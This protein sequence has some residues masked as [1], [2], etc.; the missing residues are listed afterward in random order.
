[1][2]SLSKRQY[3]EKVN[4]IK[5]QIEKGEYKW[6]NAHKNP[7]V[8]ILVK[9]GGR[10]NSLINLIHSIFTNVDSIPYKIYIADDGKRNRLKN[11]IYRRLEG[12]GHSVKLFEYNIGA[13]VSRN[14]I[15]QTIEEDFVLRLDDDFE[16]L[17]STNILTMK[18][19]LKGSSTF[20]AVSSL[21]IQI[22]H[23]KNVLDG[24]VSPHQG[25][26]GFEQDKLTKKRIDLNKT[27]FR[28]KNGNRYLICDYTRNFLLCKAEIFNDI[29][30]DERISFHG[31]HED[32]MLQIYHSE[33]DLLCT[34]D[35][36][37]GHNEK[38]PNSSLEYE[39]KRNSTK[40][41]K[42]ESSRPIQ[43]FEEKWGIK[44]IEVERTFIDYVRVIII[45]VLSYW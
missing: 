37:H 44:S 7:E 4:E 22:G 20:G 3:V 14:K 31:E 21:E 36:Y 26:F 16:L 18:S 29:K 25:F 6:H 8:A 11:K 30:W 12:G 34:P 15:V 39:R 42:K 38:I 33:W 19:I 45:K 28:H 9:T 27:A 41:G 24:Q 10:L 32:F 13:T 40:D 1:M 5:S 23:G 2:N 17:P 43:F 35:S